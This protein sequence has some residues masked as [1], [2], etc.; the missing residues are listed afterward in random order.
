MFTGKDIALAAKKDLESFFKDEADFSLNLELDSNYLSHASTVGVGKELRIRLSKSFCSAHISGIN[1]LHYFLF[2]VSHEIAHYLHAHNEHKDESDFDSKSLEAFADFFGSKIM[3]TILTYGQCFIKFYEDLG[4]KFH[5]GE[6]LDSI[7]FAFSDLA[8]NLFNTSS[9]LY[10]NRIS[11]VGHC[12]AGIMSFL[13]KKFLDTNIERSMQVL[14]RIYS[15]GNLTTMLKN[16]KER[17]IMDPSLIL[18]SDKIHKDIQGIDLEI[19]KGL[20]PTFE[21]FIGTKYFSTEKSRNTYIDAQLNLA[22]EQG[23]DIP[24]LI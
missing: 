2:I 22:K 4:F 24:R 12:S 3:M 20:K 5:F 15:A 8:E 10:S 16:E 7:S 1:D 17:F 19:T 13:D 9:D 18:R 11:R 21:I 6:V 23:F 14:T